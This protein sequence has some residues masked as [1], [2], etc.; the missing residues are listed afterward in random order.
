MSVLDQLEVATP[1]PVTQ[2][3]PSTLAIQ[4][5][6]GNFSS[7]T[8]VRPSDQPEHGAPIVNEPVTF[9]LNGTQTCTANTDA[10]G[11]ATCTITAGQPSATYTLTASF[12]GDS[13]TSTPIGSNSTSTSFTV[14]PDTS[15][16][17]YTGPTTAVNG[18]PLTLS[19]TLTSTN[20][21]SSGLSRCPPRW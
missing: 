9:T 15:S 20:V 13:S 16:L 17:V 10:T 11:T 3:V 7:P 12:S 6:T 19:G 2:T 21:P 4:P 5:V 14:T 8:P 18:Q 1:P